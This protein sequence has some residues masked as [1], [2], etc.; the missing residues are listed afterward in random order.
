MVNASASYSFWRENDTII[1]YIYEPPPPGVE[2]IN[3]VVKTGDP[4]FII[5]ATVRNDYPPENSRVC[6]DVFTNESYS[7]VSLDANVFCE[8]GTEIPSVNTDAR[9]GMIGYVFKLGVNKTRTVEIPL[10]TE[11]RDIA[12][13]EIYVHYAWSNPR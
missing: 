4:M 6:N 1:A 11:S 7:Y 12:Y 5:N 10:A 3:P 2:P 13:Y 9:K 8:N